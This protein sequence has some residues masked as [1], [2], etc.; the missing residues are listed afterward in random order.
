M[1]I[2]IRG[3]CRLRDARVGMKMAWRG[4]KAVIGNTCNIRY[5][6]LRPVARHYSVIQFFDRSILGEQ[7]CTAFPDTD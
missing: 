2:E 1:D 7:L 5:F 4:V 3:L 6:I